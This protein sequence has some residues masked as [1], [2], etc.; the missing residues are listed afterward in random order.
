MLLTLGAEFHRPDNRDRLVQ[1][2]ACFLGGLDHVDEAFFEVCPVDNQ[3]VCAQHPVD[4]LC[5]CLEVVWIGADR[6]DRD[7]ISLVVEEFADHITQDV[8]RHNNSC[9]LTRRFRIVSRR[10]VSCRRRCRVGVCRGG[11]AIRA[12]GCGGKR[13]PPDEGERGAGTEC[14]HEGGC[15]F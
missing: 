8:R 15:T 9:D 11:V 10:H 14:R 4:F 7:H 3:G 2:H 13:E 12:A 5:R 1:R 6:H